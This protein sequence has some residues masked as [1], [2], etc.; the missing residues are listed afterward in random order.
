MYFDVEIHDDEVYTAY[1]SF[2][3][4]QS[5]WINPSGQIHRFTSVEDL[6][7]PTFWTINMGAAT[8]NDFRA[9]DVT[10]DG[11]V[12]AACTNSEGSRQDFYIASFQL[13]E[14]KIH[15][16]KQWERLY[17]NEHT[18][19]VDTVFG[20]TTDQDGYIYVVGE[21][22][23]P[24]TELPHSPQVLQVVYSPQGDLASV[25]TYG[26][27]GIAGHWSKAYD[28]KVNKYGEAYL[29]GQSQYQ[30]NVAND[31]DDFLPYF[32]E[33]TNTNNT[34][35]MLTIA[36]RPSE[37]RKNDKPFYPLG[38]NYTRFTGCQTDPIQVDACNDSGIQ[39]VDFVESFFQ[40][41]FDSGRTQ[42]E[43]D[44]MAYE[45]FNIIRFFL[46]TKEL[47]DRD[48]IVSADCYNIADP[49]KS[50][51]FEESYIDNMVNMIMEAQEREMLVHLIV[52]QLPEEA[53]G[54]SPNAEGNPPVDT[55]YF[56]EYIRNA[57]RPF[58][59]GEY[60]N[61]LFF[62]R[63]DKFEG[64]TLAANPMGPNGEFDT[65]GLE[66]SLKFWKD[67]LIALK[68]HAAAN[69]GEEWED[70]ICDNLIVEP[71]A[72]P[73]FELGQL[74]PN[75]AVPFNFKFD[76]SGN[77]VD[78]ANI[79][80]INVEGQDIL[81]DFDLTDPA[82]DLN[83]PGN[84]NL[85]AERRKELM[86]NVV[87]RWANKH[88]EIATAVDP[89]IMVGS[90]P[91]TS[92]K[93]GIQPSHLSDIALPNIITL[94]EGTYFEMDIQRDIWT[95]ND[96]D[97][98]KHS[99]SSS[100][101]VTGIEF[102][103]PLSSSGG[104]LGRTSNYRPF[105]Y[106]ALLKSKLNWIG[107]N[108]DQNRDPYNQEYGQNAYGKFDERREI[109][110]SRQMLST[111]LSG[112]GL[113]QPLMTGEISFSNYMFDPLL[114]TI[115]NDNGIPTLDIPSNYYFFDNDD[116]YV[117]AADCNWLQTEL[118]RR[119]RFR[120]FMYFSWDS[121]V[122]YYDPLRNND[123][124][125]DNQYLTDPLLVLDDP[126]D[127]TRDM[128]NAGFCHENDTIRFDWANGGGAFDA[129]YSN[130]DAT[131]YSFSPLRRSNGSIANPEHYLDAINTRIEDTGL[132]QSI[133]ILDPPTNVSLQ[134]PT[135]FDIP[136]DIFYYQKHFT[137]CPPA[138]E[139][140]QTI[141]ECSQGRADYLGGI[142]PD[143]TT[144][145]CDPAALTVRHSGRPIFNYRTTVSGSGTTNLNL[146]NLFTN[147]V[148]GTQCSDGSDCKPNYSSL[149]VGIYYVKYDK[150]DAP[151]TILSSGGVVDYERRLLHSFTLDTTSLEEGEGKARLHILHPGSRGEDR[152]RL[153]MTL[154]DS[155]G[156][157]LTGHIGGGIPEIYAKEYRE[158]L[159]NDLMGVYT[160]TVE[161]IERPDFS[162]SHAVPI[163]AGVVMEGL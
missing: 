101:P 61:L 51:C 48:G 35:D 58:Q 59:L 25:T 47:T 156:N 116:L 92:H 36:S 124:E 98:M 38:F 153:S 159:V 50:L 126:A 12:V 64:A 10:N 157:I 27:A 95:N 89:Q 18:D 158:F 88:Y 56:C 74:N 5:N 108:V 14:D 161:S 115:E 57:E 1:T 138:S 102:S 87:L 150:S 67:L 105:A 16:E 28:I 31:N 136:I 148:Y 103:A 60:F 130:T 152:A 23:F 8:Y 39:Y 109:L 30:D 49:N 141:P 20:I 142:R 79:E 111:N 140:S 128:T 45:G 104:V 106:S 143:G 7:L 22:S 73:H 17:S 69:Y 68:N 21:T 99:T 113:K 121:W 107:L 127:P 11:K 151:L 120:G 4:S 81:Y 91:I 2:V 96:L 29:T 65:P 144:N 85:L 77:T 42:S 122:S 131:L 160:L 75:G 117:G 37:F 110:T 90:N 154:R 163:V 76:A 93:G 149:A 62:S 44:Q 52:Y 114:G 133:Y 41:R 84:E 46:N 146:S 24:T 80:L 119:Y 63:D 71:Y 15:L 3:V 125:G 155:Q 147:N 70:R 139:C 66:P 97:Q 132:F 19:S 82:N 123:P 86:D 32:V 43:L 112:L 53:F 9:I 145:T 26:P 78:T 129:L 118:L 33:G 162:D 40:P 72:E 54:K 135:G 83:T 13:D 34:F 100:S 94:N 137:T 6:N 134:N 55:D